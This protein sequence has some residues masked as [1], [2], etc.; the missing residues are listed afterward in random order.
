MR[1]RNSI[2]ALALVA[3]MFLPNAAAA[4]A[5][6]KAV[7][8]LQNEDGE[9]VGTVELEQTLHGTL[10][11]VQLDNLPAGTH[12]FHV[13]E[14]G[15]CEPPF[16]SAGGHFNPRNAKHGY[17]AVGGPHAGD[18]PNIH[19]PENGKLEVEYYNHLLITDQ[20]FDEDGSAVVIHKG[21]DDYETDPAGAAGVRIACGVIERTE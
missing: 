15:K 9:S 11:H 16:T 8:N 13:H 18:F 19:V 6:D 21:P 10:L 4:D 17:R 14:T 1:F 5:G 12:A 3:A 7:A 2:S 20:L